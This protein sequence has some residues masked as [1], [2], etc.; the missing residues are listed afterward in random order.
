MEILSKRS[1]PFHFTRR[2]GNSR[3]EGKNGYKWYRVSRLHLQ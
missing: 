3:V 2:K 1:N